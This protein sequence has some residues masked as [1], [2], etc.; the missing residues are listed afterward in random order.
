MTR[1][2]T[3]KLPLFILVALLI[4]LGLNFA[5]N[6][7]MIINQL[8]RAQDNQ[9]AA[10]QG[11]I[12]YLLMG[13]SHNCINPQLLGSAFNYASPNENIAQTYYKLKRLIQNQNVQV[14]HLI[15]PVDPTVF[16]PVASNR[17]KYDSYWV[18]VMDY[19]ELARVKKSR[20]FYTKW[21]TGRFFGYA[22]NYTEI[23]RSIMF[24]NQSAKDIQQGY[25]VPR[26]FKNFAQ[27]PDRAKKAEQRALLY[28]HPGDQ[29]DAVLLDYFDRL[30]ALCQAH[31]IEVIPVVIPESDAYQYFVSTL[32]EPKLYYKAAQAILDK[33]PN[34]CHPLNYQNLFHKQPAYFFNSDHLNPEGANLFTQRLAAD[35]H[36]ALTYQQ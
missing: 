21:F 30:I 16:A 2:L 9:F 14:H 1:K 26:N 20:K 31:A 34:T 29:P 15:L 28:F 19:S 17:F 32:I 6:R 18:N 22:G 35:L 23:A 11:D 27:E 3:I 5:Y 4:N 10:L 33:Y 8:N 25:R 24:A 36:S 13:N 7:Y 12:E